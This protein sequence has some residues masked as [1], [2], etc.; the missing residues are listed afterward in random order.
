MRWKVFRFIK[1]KFIVV[2]WEPHRFLI[3]VDQLHIIPNSGKLGNNAVAG[4]VV[5]T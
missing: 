5:I 3:I 2:K 1:T 4:L